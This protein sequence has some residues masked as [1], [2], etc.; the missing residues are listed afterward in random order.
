[1]ETLIA[2]TYIGK[3]PGF[4]AKVGNNIYEFEWRKSLGIGNRPDEVLPQDAEKLSEMKDRRGKKI[5]FLDKRS[6]L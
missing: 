1:M 5:F 4:I 3:L 6:L 2:I